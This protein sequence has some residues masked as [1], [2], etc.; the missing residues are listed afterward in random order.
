MQNTKTAVLLQ[1][2]FW[3]Q[4]H[5][6]CT[7]SQCIYS[8]RNTD[9]SAPCIISLLI[10]KADS[11]TFR[12]MYKIHIKV[13][14][15][16]FQILYLIILHNDDNHS[17]QLGICSPWSS[18]ESYFSL[19]ECE[20][21]ELNCNNYCASLRSDQIQLSLASIYTSDLSFC[22]FHRWKLQWK[23]LQGHRQSQFRW[24]DGSRC[25]TPCSVSGAGNW[26]YD[27]IYFMLTMRW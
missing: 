19:H 4:L 23:E 6:K 7:L 27:H 20:L 18:L 12:P 14:S 1:I 11:Y 25:V 10:M 22:H 15:L 8:K 9:Y 5:T 17:L 21:H 3:K 16:W 2:H 26:M 24:R 13:L